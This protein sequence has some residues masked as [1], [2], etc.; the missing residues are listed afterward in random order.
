MDR[1][2]LVFIHVPEPFRVVE[3]GGGVSTC[4]ESVGACVWK[5]TF[6]QKKAGNYRWQIHFTYRGETQ[7]KSL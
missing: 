5:M 6:Q 1:S 4:L 3:A 2:Y 7:L